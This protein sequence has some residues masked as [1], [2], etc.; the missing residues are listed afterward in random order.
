MNALLLLAGLAAFL[1][2]G[3]GGASPTQTPPMEDGK[4]VIHLTA[5]NRF[6]PMEA[7]VPAGATV[8]WASD[9]G[10][11]DVTEGASGSEPAWSSDADLGHK[12]MPG[13]RYERTFGT[14]G[15]VQYRCVVHASS[16]MTGTLT[17]T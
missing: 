14:P 8:V 10:L 6:V 13:E 9:A 16:G 5:A 15:V 7:T 17:V 2:A 3:C 12:M 11:H 1:L 4:Y